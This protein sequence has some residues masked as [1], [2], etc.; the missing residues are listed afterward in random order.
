MTFETFKKEF[1]GEFEKLEPHEKETLAWLGFWMA[2]RTSAT[3]LK[4]IKR[5]TEE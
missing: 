5:N 1:K 3:I 4:I 2:C